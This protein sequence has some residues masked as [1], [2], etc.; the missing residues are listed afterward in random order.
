M[1]V[2]SS[3]KGTWEAYITVN[4]KTINL[5]S[6]DSIEDAID[7]RLDAERKYEFTCDEN[8]AKYDMMC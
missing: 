8:V 6:Y 1:Y 4:Y 2:F 3:T 7:A 5:G